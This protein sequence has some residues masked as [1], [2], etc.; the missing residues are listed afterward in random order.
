MSGMISTLDCGTMPMRRAPLSSPLNRLSSWRIES[1]SSSIRSAWR[2]TT[3]PA[4][5]SATNWLLRTTSSVPRDFSRVVMLADR[6]GWV[7][8]QALAA[9]AKWRC[10]ASS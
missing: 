7:M 4:W 3:S 2:S 6:V 9:L 1:C 10:W 5:V 8:K